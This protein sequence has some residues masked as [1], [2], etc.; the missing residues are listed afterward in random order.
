[1]YPRPLNLALMPQ[2]RR[3]TP[4]RRGDDVRCVVPATDRL[5]SLA[6]SVKTT[7][8]RRLK[9]TDKEIVPE[10]PD[11]IEAELS[12]VDEETAEVATEELRK[13]ARFSCN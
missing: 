11:E 9:M 3:R 2:P 1:M 13:T 5:P 7:H 4:I 8:L 6:Y 10:N 12:D